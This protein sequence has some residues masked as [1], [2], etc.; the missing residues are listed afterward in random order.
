M[1]RGNAPYLTD[2]GSH[3]GRGAGPPASVPAG[4]P[5]D[6]LMFIFKLYYFLQFYFE[7]I[8]RLCIN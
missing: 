4:S 5:A 1:L 6:T 3:A 8:N 2:Y 7:G